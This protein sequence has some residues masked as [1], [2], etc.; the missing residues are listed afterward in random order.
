MKKI[1]SIFLTLLVLAGL[2]AC[3][4]TDILTAVDTPTK[5]PVETNVQT[6]KEPTEEPAPETGLHSIG[7]TV[8]LGDWEI[9]F[10]SFD[11]CDEIKASYGSFV[12]DE[13]NQYVVVTLTVKNLGTS[14]DS[15]LPQFAF[16]N[17]DV[18]AKIMYQNKYEFSSSNLL[19]HS[20]D[21][22]D[23]FLNPLSSATGIIAFSLVEEA[24]SSN[25][26]TMI[27]SLGKE[28]IEFDLSSPL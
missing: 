1:L 11:V 22:H 19:A 17:S 7:D 3:D 23:E 21:L 8:T 4:A 25:E 2:V 24:A 15:F 12:P 27:L 14:A 9:T 13:G 10:D 26:L 6:T 5:A 28:T 18:R 16:D 20:E